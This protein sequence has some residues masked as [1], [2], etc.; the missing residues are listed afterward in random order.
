[1]LINIMLTLLLHSSGKTRIAH[2]AL[3]SE[4]SPKLIE[5]HHHYGIRT[6]LVTAMH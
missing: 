5:R 4:L 6:A 2:P 1:M 3:S